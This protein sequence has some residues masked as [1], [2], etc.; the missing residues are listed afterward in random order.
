[1]THWKMRRVHNRPPDVGALCGRPLRGMPPKKQ[2][3]ALILILLM[4]VQ[5]LERQLLSKV[6]SLLLGLLPSLLLGPLPSLY[7]LLL[8]RFAPL[9]PTFSSHDIDFVSAFF[10]VFSVC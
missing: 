1:M 6:P 9:S 2:I 4:L 7:P 3:E 8:P 10:L 5:R